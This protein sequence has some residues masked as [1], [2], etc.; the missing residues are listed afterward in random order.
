MLT[1]LLPITFF[2]V[3]KLKSVQCVKS[4]EI[5]SFI[6]GSRSRSRSYSRS[7]SRSRSRSRSAESN[8]SGSPS[9]RKKRAIVSDSENEGNIFMQQQSK[10]IFLLKFLLIT[11][12]LYIS[13]DISAPKRPK[14][15]D[16]DNEDDEPPANETV[17]DE[18]QQQHQEQDGE[19]SDEG[20]KHDGDHAGYFTYKIQSLHYKTFVLINIFFIFLS[21]RNDMVNDFEAML[22]RKKEDQSKRRK[23]RD[24]D[25]I[26]DND[27]IIDQLIQ[28]M[29]HAAEVI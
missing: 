22:A 27:D 16:S 9:T 6:S 2:F 7:V 14:I 3:K 25:I 4:N 17:G 21:H 11:L 19:S 26:N 8:R 29:R 13:G 1:K 24:I 20:V 23:R 18:N 10:H 15:V 28:N 12:Q 5:Y